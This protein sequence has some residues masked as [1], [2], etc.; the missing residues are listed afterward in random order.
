MCTLIK[1]FGFTQLHTSQVCS[2]IL[3]TTF[4]INCLIVSVINRNVKVNFVDKMAAATSLIC[5][6]SKPKFP[7]FSCVSSS[8]YPWRRLR[9]NFIA[10][11]LQDI[12]RLESSHRIPCSPRYAFNQECFLQQQCSFK[13]TVMFLCNDLLI[14]FLSI[15]F[16]AVIQILSYHRLLRER[17]SCNKV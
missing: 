8:C 9:N 4:L 13:F 16:N 6:N 15:N 17:N 11:L 3:W 10:I 2:Y 1:L 7:V 14:C 12:F 5:Q